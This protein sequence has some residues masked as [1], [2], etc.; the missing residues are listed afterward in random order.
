[1][2][3]CPQTTGGGCIIITAVLVQSNSHG[4]VVFAHMK[5]H[6]VFWVEPEHET[7]LQP[8]A[9]QGDIGSG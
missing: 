1:M 3:C 8:G 4:V 6:D 9:V 2:T 5:L 7:G